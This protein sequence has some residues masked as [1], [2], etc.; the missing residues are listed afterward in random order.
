VVVF[1]FLARGDFASLCV[2]VPL[3]PWASRFFN[4]CA[5]SRCSVSLRVAVLRLLLQEF[6]DSIAA[7]FVDFRMRGGSSISLEHG[8][9]LITFVR[10]GSAISFPVRVAVVAYANTI[11]AA[12][13]EPSLCVEAKVNELSLCG[14]VTVIEPSLWVGAAGTEPSLCTGAAVAGPSV[15][16]GV[17]VT[18]CDVEIVSV[19]TPAGRAMMW[20]LGAQQGT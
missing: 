10:G 6:L 5:G 17:V 12:V 1:Y 18:E 4:S 19:A 13:T 7:G 16:A 2:V 9:A 11:E 14:G 20:V 3:I 15:C 8:C